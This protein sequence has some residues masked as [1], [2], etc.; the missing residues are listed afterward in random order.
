VLLLLLPLL[1]GELVPLAGPEKL[2][3]LDDPAGFTASDAA[4]SKFPA[5]AAAAGEVRLLL[6]AAA[7]CMRVTAS[8]M[9]EPPVLLLLP[10]LLS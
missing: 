5:A 8:D 10:L 1:P 9:S 6:L 4:G 3:G 7:A 2:M